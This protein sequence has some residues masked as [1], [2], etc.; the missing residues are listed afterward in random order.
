M[1]KLEELK[2]TLDNANEAYQEELNKPK[3]WSPDVSNVNFNREFYIIDYTFRV[4][5]LHSGWLTKEQIMEF[6]N[7]GNYFDMDQKGIA[8]K[9]ADRR[10]EASRLSAYVRE[11]DPEFNLDKRIGSGDALFYV[12]YNGG[13]GVHWR[14]NI[15]I[16]EVYMSETVA[17]ELAEKLNNSE[18]TFKRSK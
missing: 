2:V 15:H 8:E 6:V 1:T 17:L 7:C 5:M 13:Y 9:E 4:R 11:F 14:H 16:G 10:Y 3:V 18:V 12:Y